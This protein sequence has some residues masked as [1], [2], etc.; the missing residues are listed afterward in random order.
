MV[1]KIYTFFVIRSSVLQREVDNLR[2]EL[3]TAN[4]RTTDCDKAARDAQVYIHDS[5][6]LCPNAIMFKFTFPKYTS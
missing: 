1:T 3:E 4:Q 2:R 5:S 6:S